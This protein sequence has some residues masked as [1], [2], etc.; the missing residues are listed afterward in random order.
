[1]REGWREGKMDPAATI[2][3]GCTASGSPL[4]RRRG[5]TGRE[6]GAA[7]GGGVAARVAQT[8]RRGAGELHS[9]PWLLRTG[10]LVVDFT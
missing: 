2:L 1:M 5:G 3:A 9:P 7:G 6:E 10:E 4:R 8:G